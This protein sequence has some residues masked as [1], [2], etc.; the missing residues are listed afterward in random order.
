MRRVWRE[1]GLGGRFGDGLTVSRAGGRSPRPAG[2][3]RELMTKGGAAS[4]SFL[5]SC[6][7]VFGFTDTLFLGQDNP[8]PR[9]VPAGA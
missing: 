5:Q 4:A 3:A 8:N 1:D 2:T 9:E 7:P 6:V